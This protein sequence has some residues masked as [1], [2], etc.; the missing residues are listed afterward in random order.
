M[1]GH[2]GGVSMLKAS[3]KPLPPAVVEQAVQRVLSTILSVTEPVAVVLFGSAATGQM[4]DQSDIDLCLIFPDEEKIAAKRKR[5]ATRMPLSKY[6]VD[7]IVVHESEFR[8]KSATGG[9][10]LIIYQD[11]RWLRGSKEQFHDKG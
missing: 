8:R 2:V 7:L 1:L 9:I 6:P 4:T 5:I 11:G 3:R 10:C